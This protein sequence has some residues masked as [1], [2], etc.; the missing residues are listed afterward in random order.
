MNIDFEKG[1]KE[2]TEKLHISNG[3]LECEKA[4]IDHIVQLPSENIS[5]IDIERYLK[6]LLQ[7]FQ[8]LS[9]INKNTE[10][11]INCVYAAA[12]LQTLTSTPYWQSWITIAN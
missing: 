9:I 5:L 6:K 3:Y 8:D 10:L 1:V 4:I 2:I 12:F 7:Y 11:G